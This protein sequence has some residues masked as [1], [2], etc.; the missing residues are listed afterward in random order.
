MIQEY[1]IHSEFSEKQLN[2]ISTAA[3]QI[4]KS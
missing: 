4:K 3:P 1:V 2:G